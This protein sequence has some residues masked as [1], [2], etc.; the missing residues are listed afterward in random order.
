VAGALVVLLD[1]LG[2]EV[3]RT[4]S[5]PTGGFGFTPPGPGQYQIRVLRIGFAGWLSPPVTFTQGERRETRFIIEDRIIQLAAIEVRATRSRCGVRPGDG[6]IIAS[7]LN[8]AEKA[9]AITDQTIRQGSLRFRTETFLSRP[10]PDGAPGERQAT[11]SSGQAMWPVA[12]APPDSLAKYGFVHEV[13][14]GPLDLRGE[15]GPVYFGPDAR[16]LFAG[17][18]L[19]SHCFSVAPTEDSAKNIVVEFVPQRSNSRGDIRGRLTLDRRSLELRSLQFWYAGLGRWVPAN[20]AGG[21]LSF[22]R[23]NSGAWIIDRWVLRAPIP[24]VGRRD[25]T[26]FGFAESGG[27]VK[28][29]RDGR[30]GQVET[31][32]RAAPDLPSGDASLVNN[33]FSPLSGSD[34]CAQHGGCWADLSFSLSSPL[35][36]H[37]LRSG[38]WTR[39]RW[40]DPIGFRPELT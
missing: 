28:E 24:I 16:V 2:R 23:L 21:S 7:L 31:I 19:D 26:L 36:K 30:T 34:L 15:T 17:W 12:S 9:L 22:R 37:R 32:S 4:L 20:T 40:R 18:F 33:R 39:K 6:D 5:S 13:E 1:S 38:R 29:I 10:T 14:R 27:Q 25:T 8:E 35:D 11:S 3:R